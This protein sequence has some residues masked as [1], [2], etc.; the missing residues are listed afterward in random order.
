MRFLDFSTIFEIF[1]IL[2]FFLW[3]FLIF[4]GFFG[5]YRFFCVFFGIFFCILGDFFVFFSKLLKLLLKVT[6]VT[7]EHHKL[8]KMGQNS[9]ISYFFAQ[10][11]TKSLGRSPA[12]ELEVGPRS[13]PYLLVIQQK[14]YYCLEAQILR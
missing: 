14:G 3:I 6:K 10:R 8:P 11:A 1:E 12:Q 13:G 5:F 7:T 4:F 9:I 2:V